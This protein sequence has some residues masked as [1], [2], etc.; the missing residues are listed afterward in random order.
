MTQFPVNTTV[1]VHDNKAEME[2][3][4]MVV[5]LIEHLLNDLFGLKCIKKIDE[6]SLKHIL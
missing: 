3:I 5:I 4:L 6:N 1:L 2:M